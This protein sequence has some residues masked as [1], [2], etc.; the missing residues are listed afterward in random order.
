[1]LV[2]QTLE[3][4]QSLLLELPHTLLDSLQSV[5]ESSLICLLIELLVPQRVNLLRLVLLLLLQQLLL[6][7]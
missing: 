5:K 7:R 1:M 3:L 4:T 2:L 6:P